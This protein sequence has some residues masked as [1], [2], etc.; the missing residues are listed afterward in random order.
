MAGKPDKADKSAEKAPAK[1]SGGSGGP[2]RHKSTMIMVAVI[3]AVEVVAVVAIVR[4][5]AGPAS[6]DA[7][8]IA[9]MSQVV[10]DER[11]IETMVL[12]AKLPNARTG[13]TYLYDAEI[14]VQTQ[15]K[16]VLRVQRELEQFSNEIRASISAI[17]RTAE[18][19]HFQ[20]PNLETLTRNVRGLLSDRMGVDAESG[21]PIIRKCVIVMG[22]GFRIDN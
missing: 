5:I 18:P 19:H 9:E 1:K 7:A 14:Y 6:V 4:F 15:E 20:E 8:A 13:I 10:G 17:W 12:H 22:T 2:G 3:L 16:H 21:E 11:I